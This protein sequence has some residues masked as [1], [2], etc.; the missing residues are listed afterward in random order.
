ML[1]LTLEQL[2]QEVMNLNA[3]EQA[4]LLRRM[5]EKFP[6]KQ[7]PSEA[8]EV[9]H[10]ERYPKGSTVRREDEYEDE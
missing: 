6:P 1:N 2:W 9:F 4:E 3:Q 8:L 5:Q 7:R 10:V